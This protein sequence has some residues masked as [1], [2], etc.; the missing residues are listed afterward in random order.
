VAAPF[1]A[2]VLAVALALAAGLSGACMERPEYAG[3]FPLPADGGGRTLCVTGTGSVLLPVTHVDFDCVIL[4]DSSSPQESWTTAGIR[5]NLLMRAL[6]EE[7]VPQTAMVPRAATLAREADGWR[8]TQHLQVAL[9]DL[10]R[11]PRLLEVVMGQAGGA[12]GVTNVRSGHRHP[13]GAADRAR[14]RALLDARDTAEALAGELGLRLGEVQSVEALL[15][16]TLGGDDAPP[17]DA[18]EV[19]A[20]LRVTWRLEP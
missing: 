15:P 5:M 11:M 19:V 20:R 16:E 6:S 7:G 13:R 2:P 17:G 10:S 14:E 3:S 8:V 4:S 9:D 12:N 1:T 18:L